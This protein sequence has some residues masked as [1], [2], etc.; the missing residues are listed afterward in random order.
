MNEQSYPHTPPPATPPTSGMAIGSLI[1]SIAGFI[2]V[3]ILGGIVG[4]ILGYV[5]KKQIR[6]S[7]GTLAGEGLA[8]AGIIMGWIQVALLVVFVV[9]PIC[10]IVLLTL[11][12]PG[13]GDIFSNI[14]MGI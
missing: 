2:I 6:E 1:A 13:I 11:M 4:L 14:M 12:G 9:L 10:V 5:A 8:T 7:E 3:P